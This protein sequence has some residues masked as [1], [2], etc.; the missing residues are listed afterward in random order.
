MKTLTFVLGVLLLGA[1]LAPPTMAADSIAVK[2]D[3]AGFGY[4]GA[5]DTNGDGYFVSLTDAT[6]KGTFGKSS[7]AIT[8]E[9][10]ASLAASDHSDCSDGPY[11]PYLWMPVISDLGADP[12]HYYAFVTTA[13]D[14]SQVFGFFDQGYL[15]I[16]LSDPPFHWFGMT[17]GVF[18][19]GTGRYEAA[20]GTW[21]SHYGGFNLDPS[22]GLRSIRGTIEGELILP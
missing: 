22:I 4:D 1:L 21:I 15:C 17:G 5:V 14:F 11:G 6:G 9:F 19:G 20:N 7:I 2:V 3:Y 12:R 8:V 16:N 13:A 10:D 18:M